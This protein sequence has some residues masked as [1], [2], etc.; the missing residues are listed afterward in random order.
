[1]EKVLRMND[2]E[3]LTCTHVYARASMHA[4]IHVHT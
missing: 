3:I 1:M 2:N 4:H